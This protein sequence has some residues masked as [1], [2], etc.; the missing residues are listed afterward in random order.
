MSGLD[1]LI[2]AEERIINTK[3]KITKNLVRASRRFLVLFVPRSISS[4]LGCE[5][6][7]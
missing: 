3:P 2:G 4:L 6:R 7:R 1:G 5:Q